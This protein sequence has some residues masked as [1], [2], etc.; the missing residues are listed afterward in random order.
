M[1]ATSFAAIAA[2]TM[3]SFTILAAEASSSCKVPSDD[4]AKED[5][6]ACGG[7]AAGVHG[8]VYK[9]TGAVKRVDK[10]AGKVT[11]AHDA[12]AD[13]NWPA[14]TMQFGVSDR[15]LLGEMAPGRK[16][17]FRFVQRESGYVVTAVY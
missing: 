15:K 11:I 7:H 10:S 13:L 12:I 9:A 4:P 3:L 16:V 8:A 5:H 17:D 14:M 1:R 2:A 6:G